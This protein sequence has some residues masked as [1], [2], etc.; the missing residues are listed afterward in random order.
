MRSSAPDQEVEGADFDPEHGMVATSTDR[1]RD[2]EPVRAKS[3]GGGGGEKD[4]E[5]QPNDLL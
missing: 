1:V 2:L 4:G 5:G 3:G